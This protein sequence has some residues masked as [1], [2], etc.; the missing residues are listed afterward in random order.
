MSFDGPRELTDPRA[1]RAMAHPV[2]LAL[3]EALNHRGPMTAT[4]AAELV[5]ESPSAYRARWAAHGAPHV[6]G[7]WLFM[8]GVLDLGGTS[9]AI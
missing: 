3:M 2:R 7:C 5:G 6:P 9:G 8:R 4:E 1:M